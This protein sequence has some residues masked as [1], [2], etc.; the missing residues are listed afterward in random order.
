[1]APVLVCAQAINGHGAIRK[2][3]MDA[4][5]HITSGDIAGNAL[6]ESGIPG[7]VFVWRDILY[8]GPRIPGWPDQ[9]TI[10]ARA[11]F[12]VQ[13]TAGGLQHD[14]VRNGLQEQYQTLAASGAYARIILWFDACLFDQSML[15]HLL[16]CLRDRGIGQVDLLCV[17]HFPGIDPYNGLGQLTPAQLA[18][19]YGRQI[20][21]T[22]EQFDFARTVDQ[23]FADQDGK[24]FARLARQTDAPLPWIPAAVTRWLA[25]QPDPKT[26]LGRLDRLVLDAL[27]DGKQTPWQIFHAVAAADVPPQ[28]WG[29]T[30]LWARINRLAD[31]TPP[32][33]RIQGPAERLPQW[34]SDLDL[35][36][37]SLSC[38]T[39]PT[40]SG[41]S[42]PAS[43]DSIDATEGP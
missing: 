26:G 10:E 39:D 42:N 33:V 11:R 37:F 5:L 16:T 9:Q 40:D 24:R 12:L 7:K 22:D 2:A 23:A 28:Y 6:Q 21:V 41:G 18:S 25:E 14:D 30:T 1:M 35:N 15:V 34:Q 38:Q 32:L 4:I 13:A 20:P 19:L 3:D 31:F 8:D 29:D 43:Q 27:R 17:D 36:Q